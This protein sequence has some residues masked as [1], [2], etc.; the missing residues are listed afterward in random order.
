[1]SLTR[2]INC[3]S[4][5]NPEVRSMPRYDADTGF[6]LKL[7][8]MIGEGIAALVYL[9]SDNARNALIT[10]GVAAAVYLAGAAK[11]YLTLR[12]SDQI[13]AELEHHR[14][15]PPWDYNQKYTPTL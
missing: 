4:P 2:I 11:D 7:A 5:V 15:L 14:R 6:L 3:L 12:R 8:G 10:A 1:M 13:F 9:N